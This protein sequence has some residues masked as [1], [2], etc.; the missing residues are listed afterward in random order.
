MN[1]QHEEHLKMWFKSVINLTRAIIGDIPS[2]PVITDEFDQCLG[3]V[4]DELAEALTLIKSGRAINKA[5]R[6]E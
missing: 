4:E 5:G 1:P 6:D 2:S 3:H